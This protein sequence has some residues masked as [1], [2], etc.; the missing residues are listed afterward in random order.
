MSAVAGKRDPVHRAAD[1]ISCRSGI[2]RT[3]LIG[4][5]S[6]FSDFL[7]L[8]HYGSLTSVS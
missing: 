2:P 4:L 3:R 7:D 8:W 6:S 5:R 1:G